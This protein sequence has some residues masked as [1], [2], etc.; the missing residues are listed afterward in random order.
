MGHMS[1]VMSDPI[2]NNVSNSK[3]NISGVSSCVD[4]CGTSFILEGAASPTKMQFVSPRWIFTT[5]FHII[6]LKG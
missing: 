3:N 4:V 1:V 2:T 5:T 6:I